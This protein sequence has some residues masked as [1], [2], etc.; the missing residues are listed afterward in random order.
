MVEPAATPVTIPVELP[1][2][3]IEGLALVHTPPLTECV[4]VV[5]RPKHT[6][7]VPPIVAS[8]VFIVT[9]VT[10]WQPALTV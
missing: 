8:V 5:V 1:I 10:L 7:G 2:L 3:A 9:V 6:F 4:S